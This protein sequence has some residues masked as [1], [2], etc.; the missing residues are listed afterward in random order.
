V[1]WPEIFFALT[2]FS[3]CF[4]FAVNAYTWR[5]GY[6]LWPLV[7][8]EDFGG[9]HTRYLARLS[10]VITIPHVLMFFASACL[11]ATRPPWFGA[12]S[13]FMTCAL[14]WAVVGISAFLAGPVHDR[15]SKNARMDDAGFEQLIWIS[16]ARTLMLLVASGLLFRGMLQGLG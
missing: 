5:I 13:A 7:A 15:F 8:D 16:I 6:A 2:A 3:V 4:C 11:A 10:S 12:V 9:F 1:R 14:A